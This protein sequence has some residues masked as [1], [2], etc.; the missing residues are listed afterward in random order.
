MSSI[1]QIE[2]RLFSG[3]TL[4]KTMD[5]DAASGASWAF[6]DGRTARADLCEKMLA[7]GI[8]EPLNDGLFPGASQTYS[9][10]P[11]TGDIADFIVDRIGPDWVVAKRRT[12]KLLEQYATIVLPREY[13]AAEREWKA[14]HRVAEQRLAA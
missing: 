1:V 11:Y 7:Q 2:S 9:L 6:D 14:R 3:R 13:A 12:K 4:I 10:A 5:A 8:I